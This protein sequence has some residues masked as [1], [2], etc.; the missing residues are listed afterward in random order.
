S[1]IGELFFDAEKNDVKELPSDQL[2]INFF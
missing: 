1:A 2:T